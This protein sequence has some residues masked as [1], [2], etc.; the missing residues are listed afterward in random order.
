[1][2]AV[3]EVIRSVGL[4]CTIIR[5]G[6]ST[7]GASPWGTFRWGADDGINN[8]S[9][10]I[11]LNPK[12]AKG[13]YE[14]NPMLPTD[15]GVVGGDLIQVLTDYYLVAGLIEDRRV[16]EFFNYKAR[17][18]KCNSVV[19]VRAQNVG[20]K[21]FANVSTGVRCL[22]TQTLI[23]ASEDKSIIVPGYGGKD[24]LFYCFVALTA[25]VNKNNILVDSIGR[26]F[27]VTE[28]MDPLYAPGLLRAMV[29]I[30]NA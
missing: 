27:R 12:D 10:Y 28:D 18:F 19:T 17:L 1:M 7:W 20:T 29:K 2:G 5:P 24:R 14:R 30:E 13:T 21:L 25:G 11:Y 8:V 4:S 6:G 26:A 3:D 23:G 22:I 9:T 15:C 16:G